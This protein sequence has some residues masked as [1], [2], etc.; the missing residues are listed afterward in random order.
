VGLRGNVVGAFSAVLVATAIAPG[1]SLGQGQGAVTGTLNVPDCWSGSFDLHPDFF[2]A[3]P[4][5]GPNGVRSATTGIEIRIQNGG[6]FESFSDGLIIVVDDA[7]L[8][9]G[10][11]AAD[12]TSRP[13]LLNTPLVVSLAPGVLPPGVPVTPIAN[14]PIVHASLYLNRTCRT[15]NDALYALDAVTVNSADP[16]HDCDRPDGGEAPLPCGTPAVASGADGGM[17]AGDAMTP[18][19]DAAAPPPATGLVRQSTITFA[20]L[21]D[22]NP[23]EA[24]AGERLTNVPSFDFYLAD[25]REICPGGLGPPPRCRGHIKGWFNFYF[26]RG[27]P[28][29]PFP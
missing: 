8:V 24:N 1:C 4:Q 7:G 3:V 14:P 20:H 22:G 27:R 15:Q 11:P 25:P 12:G 5:T 19:G 16:D 9:R 23:D 13:G 21:F 17:T 28:A 2:A 10:D 18:A 29:Q 6:D 26:Q